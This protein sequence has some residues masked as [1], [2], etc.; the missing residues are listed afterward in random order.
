MLIP[1]TPNTSPL[2]TRQEAAEY[3]GVSPATLAK[4][5]SEKTQALPYI[6]VGRLVRY[7]IADLDAYISHSVAE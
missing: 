2:L 6:K 4:W 3:L 1:K 7:R 5:A